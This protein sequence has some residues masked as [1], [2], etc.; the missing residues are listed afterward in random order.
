MS[1][2]FGDNETID[3]ELNYTLEKNKSGVTQVTIIDN[4]KAAKL[5][6]DPAHKVKTLR[7]QWKPL[8]WHASNELI[9]KATTFNHHT[10]QQDIDYTKFRDAKLKSCL[11]GW[12]AKNDKGEPIPCVESAINKLHANVALA[13][14]AK[15]DDAI[16]IPVENQAK[17]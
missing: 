7:T 13:L 17:N 4:E 8:T 9:T 10:Q 2:I 3:I 1:D 5:K 15:Y 14:L 16:T 6:A 11:L 12:D